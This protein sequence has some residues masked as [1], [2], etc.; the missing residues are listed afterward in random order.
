MSA[1]S[2]QITALRHEGAAL[3]AQSREAKACADQAVKDDEVNSAMIEMTTAMVLARYG[4]A[5]LAAADALQA[6]DERQ[7][8]PIVDRQPEGDT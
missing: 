4:K 8:I 6:E 3:I 1:L 2:V 5:K 7:R